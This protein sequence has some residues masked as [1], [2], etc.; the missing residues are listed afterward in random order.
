V[1]P[2]AGLD[3]VEKIFDPSVNQPVAS[4]YTDCAIP[5]PL[6]FEIKM[7]L[8]ETGSENMDCIHMI[9]DRDQ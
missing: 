8:K 3:G 2:R 7:D 6:G 1:D 4:R 5:V 9:Q